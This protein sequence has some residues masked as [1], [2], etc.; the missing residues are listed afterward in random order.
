[1]SQ[2]LRQVSCRKRRFPAVEYVHRRTVM[3]PCLPEKAGSVIDILCAFL[4][5]HVHGMCISRKL[6]IGQSIDIFAVFHYGHADSSVNL[7]DGRCTGWLRCYGASAKANQR[8]AGTQQIFAHSYP[9]IPLRCF[10]SALLSSGRTDLQQPCGGA[11]DA[12]IET[13]VYDLLFDCGGASFVDEI[14]LRGI[15]RTVCI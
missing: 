5:Q 9:A 11:Y 2:Q 3:D 14:E 15:M 1:M 10:V 13:H 7:R 12:A 8:Q 4:L 6:C